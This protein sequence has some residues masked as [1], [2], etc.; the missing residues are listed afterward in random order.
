[1]T[2]KFAVIS[3]IGIISTFKVWA[4]NSII[5]IDN[6]SYYATWDSFASCNVKDSVAKQC[7][8]KLQC[9]VKSENSLCDKDPKPGWQ[10]T[11]TIQ[12]HCG[13]SIYKRREIADEGNTI[14]LD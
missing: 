9:S 3:L 12:Y 14:L 7:N 6:A 1:M 4:D 11:L 5:T 10:K 8:G 13:D 2:H